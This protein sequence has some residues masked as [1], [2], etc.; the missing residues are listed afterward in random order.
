[1]AC[2]YFDS[3]VCDHVVEFPTAIAE[4]LLDGVRTLALMPFTTGGSAVTHGLSTSNGDEV[5]CYR[6]TT[7]RFFLPAGSLSPS[8]AIGVLSM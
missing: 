1:M 4:G 3:G 8:L 5:V 2:T 6:C 7:V